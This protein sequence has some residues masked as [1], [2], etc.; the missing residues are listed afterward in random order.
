MRNPEIKA[1]RIK[2]IIEEQGLSFGP[3][4]DNRTL[5]TTPAVKRLNGST[6]RIP[7]MIGTN[8]QEGRI[9]V[10][11]QNDVEKYARTTFR[12]NSAIVKAVLDAYVVGKNGLE[13]GFDAIA[14]IM[15]EFTFQCVSL[16]M[17]SLV[18]S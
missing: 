11:G 6:T 8:A 17:K 15:T 16:M 9:F 4:A 10:Q 14:Q 1:E 3:V 18:R 12:N 2:K 7:V 5:W 13:T